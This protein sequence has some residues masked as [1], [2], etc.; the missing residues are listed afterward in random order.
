[1][2]SGYGSYQRPSPWTPPGEY[3]FASSRSFR[4][5]SVLIVLSTSGMSPPSSDGV[6]GVRCYSPMRYSFTALSQTIFFSTAGSSWPM[7]SSTI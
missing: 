1:M 7:V 2:K 5:F 6:A 3:F 4:V